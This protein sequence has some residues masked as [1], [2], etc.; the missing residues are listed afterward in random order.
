MK[1]LSFQSKI[2]KILASYCGFNGEDVASAISLQFTMWCQLVFIDK[3]FP[4]FK[5]EDH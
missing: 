1:S 2:G 4:D 3:S 5:Q